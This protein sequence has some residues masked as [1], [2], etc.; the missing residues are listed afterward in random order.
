MNLR[1]LSAILTAPTCVFA[2]EPASLKPK[3]TQESLAVLKQ[4]FTYQPSIRQEAEQRKDADPDIVTMAR[5]IVTESLRQKELNAKME[6]TAQ[7]KK[8]E[9]FTPINGGTILEIGRMKIGTW[10]DP[11]GHPPGIKFIKMK[12]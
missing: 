4:M 12:F 3:V 6:R 9:Q 5:F 8:A 1:L 10:P 2:A 11:D 7:E